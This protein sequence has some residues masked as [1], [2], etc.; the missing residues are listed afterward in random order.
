[1]TTTI[2]ALISAAAVI[3]TRHH[4]TRIIAKRDEEI[5][6]LILKVESLDAIIDANHKHGKMLVKENELLLNI[7]TVGDNR[8]LWTDYRKL[9]G[10]LEAAQRTIEHLQAI[11]TKVEEK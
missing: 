11:I 4:Y 10:K 2:F 9:E 7:R 3:A 8:R 5:R 1:M 6:F